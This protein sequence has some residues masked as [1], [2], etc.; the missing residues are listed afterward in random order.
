[1]THLRW[2]AFAFLWSCLDEPELGETSS[3]VTQLVI[4]AEASSG[5]G[6]VEVDATASAGAVRTMPTSQ[7]VAQQAFLTTGTLAAGS[8][9]VRGDGCNPW[10]RVELDT[11]TV[12][13]TQL[14]TTSWT[15]LPFSTLALPAGAHTIKFH[16]RSGSAGCVLRFDHATLT[17][18]DPPPPPP[19]P[20]PPVVV[21]AEL[22]TGAGSV[23]PDATASGGALR[24]F[25][26]AY[27]HA[28]ASFAT[29]A[30]MQGSVRVRAA[31]C[32]AAPY[33]KVYVDGV[34]VLLTTVASAAWLELPLSG[35]VAAGA[36]VIDFEYRYGVAPCQLQIDKATFTVP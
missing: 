6:V 24:A 28:I 33:V 7:T 31:S 29:T 26:S 2:F 4:E 34:A 5:A 32:S 9:R 20:P 15:T 22:A 10:V 17:V 1:M 25:P 14:M 21:E 3:A 27:T 12:V 19:P 35:F 23:V 36:H 18:D 13:S 30:T 8:V 16:Y 11:Y